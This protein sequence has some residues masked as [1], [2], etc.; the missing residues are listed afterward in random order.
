MKRI[1][2]KA[3]KRMLSALVGISILCTAAVPTLAR[4]M[5][6][7]KTQDGEGQI[8]KTVWISGTTNNMIESNIAAGDE[9]HPKVNRITTTEHY[10]EATFSEFREQFGLSEGNVIISFD[11]KAGQSDHFY[12]FLLRDTGGINIAQFALDA[13][14]KLVIT[15]SPQDRNAYPQ[16]TLEEYGEEYA[17]C[18]YLPD[19]WYTLRLV[20]NQ[21]ENKISYYMNGQLVGESV[22]P[23]QNFWS[24]T[25]TNVPQML[26]LSPAVSDTNTE[27]IDFDNFSIDRYYPGETM[28]AS[29]SYDAKVVTVLFDE[30]LSAAGIAAAK[31]A[32]VKNLE[33]S[34]QIPAE[35]IEAEGREL[36]ILLAGELEED[37]E[38]AVV[39]PD[40]IYSVTG[41]SAK[42]GAVYFN[43]GK[44]GD[45]IGAIAAYHDF[46]TGAVHGY[47][48][49]E[50]ARYNT[51][52]A[53]VFI[54]GV[55]VVDTGD[56]EH[57]K[58]LKFE[59][60]G[61]FQ[62]IHYRIKGDDINKSDEAILSFDVMLGQEDSN[63]FTFYMRMDNID[64][65]PYHNGF[66][67]VFN[68]VGNL[69]WTRSCAVETN[70]ILG[71]VSDNPS[72]FGQVAY[73]A[74]EWHNVKLVVKRNERNEENSADG[75]TY[76]YFDDV[77]VGKT[78]RLADTYKND[79]D[80]LIS[81]LRIETAASAAGK[82]DVMYVD[83]IKFGFKEHA[84]IENV[85][86]NGADGEVYAPLL[87]TVPTDILGGNLYFGEF[88]GDEEVSGGTVT[89][90]D[91]TD[92]IKADC[93][94][95]D[96]AARKL[97]FTL[98]QYLKPNTE[99]TLTAEGFKTESGIIIDDFTLGFKTGAGAQ[100]SVNE[101]SVVN[102]AGEKLTSKD[103]M[104]AGGKAFVKLDI[105]NDTGTGKKAVLILSVYNGD[106]LVSLSAKEIGTEGGFVL[107]QNS[108]DALGVTIN[109]TQQLSIKAYL[110]DSQVLMKPWCGS[111][112]F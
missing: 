108:P 101:F 22:C 44:Q 57:A 30:Y 74:N 56:P 61:E 51:T 69:A 106:R 11:F 92:M 49:Q 17:V 99:Y 6:S 103:Q 29:V 18:D 110:W 5:E 77:L 70:A 12:K 95:Y 98:S 59:S 86:F 50:L 32:V 102:E 20:L 8:F 72:G 66:Y 79:T 78:K 3:K 64:S 2:K 25:K 88:C 52:E 94:E 15:K 43:T 4:P 84:N 67:G 100:F 55:S 90:S 27:Y 13:A 76:I 14:G 87:Q 33:N 83:N 89:I 68:P 105:T 65:P 39:F 107:D 40:V 73:T 46:D 21:D 91:G 42:S 34:E 41:N 38:Y 62:C 111:V 9:D 81:D 24:Y 28:S 19:T 10:K 63:Y 80:A 104:A 75:V 82:G 7:I 53:D 31:G 48:M 96:V 23:T 112:G 36:S 58:A 16:T 71:D 35:K 45:Y 97:P 60:N 47:N 93:G 1:F 26:F 85:E 109:D 37:A 54:N